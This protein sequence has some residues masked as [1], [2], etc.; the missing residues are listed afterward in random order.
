MLPELPIELRSPG[1]PKLTR[2]TSSPPGPSALAMGAAVHWQGNLNWTNAGVQNRAYIQQIPPG[3]QHSLVV[4]TSAPAPSAGC[5][6]PLQGALGSGIDAADQRRGCHVFPALCP[7]GFVPAVLFLHCQPLRTFL[8]QSQE[9]TKVKSGGRSRKGPSF[10]K[11]S[12]PNSPG[13]STHN[14]GIIF[15]TLNSP[16]G[17]QLMPRFSRALLPAAPTRARMA[18][19]QR[20]FAVNM[21]RVQR[22][23]GI[24]IS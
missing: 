11:S 8:L 17:M 20:S 22:P 21:P 13:P 7:A 9:R 15:K 6:H 24:T 23:K 10:P 4:I 3:F 16:L 1:C 12:G 19:Y 5:K 18:R 2:T 14:W